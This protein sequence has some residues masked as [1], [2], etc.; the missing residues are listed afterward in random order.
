MLVNREPLVVVVGVLAPVVARQELRRLVRL[1]TQVELA[2]HR[3]LV[4]VPR[5]LVGQHEVVVRLE[6]FGIHREGLLELLDGLLDGGHIQDAGVEQEGAHDGV[7]GEGTAEHDQADLADGARES[8]EFGAEPERALLTHLLAYA[9][10]LEQVER[11]SDPSPLS[12]WIYEGAR[13]FSRFY[14]DCP[15]L[16]ADEPLRSARLALILATE[17][18]LGHGLRTL[19]IE[20]V[21]QM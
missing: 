17:R 9:G 6:I 1:E 13:A 15:V 2:V 7:L 10:V 19:G 21:E 14:H 8:A 5:A 4:G 18:I 12:A 20:P 11:T 16:S 3:R